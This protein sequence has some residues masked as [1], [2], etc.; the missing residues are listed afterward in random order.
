[1]ENETKQD[2]RLRELAPRDELQLII[3]EATASV[4]AHLALED[5]GWINLS[6]TSAD[7]PTSQERIMNLK[8]SRLYALKDPLGVQ[9]IRLWTDYTFGP[10]MTWSVKDTSKDEDN[11]G[12]D[13][14]EA[15][16]KALEAF[17]D[18]PANKAVL[19]ARGQRKSSDKLLVDGEIF[20]ALF[21][22]AQGA[23]TI[24]WI[25]PLEI[26]EI[27][28][29]PNDKEKAMFYRREWSDAQGT[30][31]KAIYRS[32]INIK[33]VAAVDASGTIIKQTD[34]AVVYHLTRGTTTQRGNPLLLPVLTWMKYNTKFQ[35]SRIAINLALAKFAWRQKVKGGQT[36][37]D[38]V[39]AKTHEED[40]SAGSTVVE[41]FGVDTTPIKTET[42]GKASAEDGRQ[43]KLMFCA[44]VGWYEQYFGDISTGN[45][46]TAKTVELPVYKMI[47]SYQA[48]WNDAYQDIDEIVLE[49]AGIKPDKW[50]VDRDFPPIAPHD[51]ATVAE[52]L[53]KIIGVMPEF[54][55]AE[56][57]KQLA[58]VML[59]INDPKE[60][61]EELGK[62][63]EEEGKAE[64]GEG[65][66]STT[67]VKLLRVAQ[68]LREI[69][70]QKGGT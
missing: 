30:G 24:R 62:A 49:H 4:E 70:K 57:I 6:G 2:T 65:T 7:L 16:R 54:A 64:G 40:V 23:V 41:S 68:L 19:S 43:I 21:L 34:D 18:A 55:D 13:S 3:K 26:T 45:L 22:G 33:D 11:G 1:M 14:N 39:K 35:A 31:H 63:K 48:V 56:D 52:A 20:F 27:I 69:A 46:A 44:G 59:G 25:D 42:G 51:V 29:D 8:L 47:Q 66:E 60:V 37:V 53:V 28:T 61:L 15:T 5:A 58:L 50:Y 67:N 9:A 36:A 10:G 17:W 38:T 12:V 32:A